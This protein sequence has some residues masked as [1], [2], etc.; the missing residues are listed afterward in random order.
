[1]QPDN[2]FKIDLP[3]DSNRSKPNLVADDS[4]DPDWLQKTAAGSPKTVVRSPNANES[5]PDGHDLAQYKQNRADE[6][7]FSTSS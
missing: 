5:I 6:Q 1:L 7:Y 4:E 2:S 3:H